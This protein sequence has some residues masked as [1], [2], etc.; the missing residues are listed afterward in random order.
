[1]TRRI[2]FYAVPVA[3]S[4]YLASNL[5]SSATVFDTSTGHPG[6]AIHG[7]FYAPTAN[8]SLDGPNGSGVFHNG[9]VAHDVHLK[10]S[11]SVNAGPSL[12]GQ[13]P[14]TF[15]RFVQIVATS[16]DAGRRPS[17]R[18]PSSRSTTTLTRRR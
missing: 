18:A 3:T 9:T 12:C 10:I 7:L 11:A 6:V 8:L 2:S 1:M 14:R 15:K 5:P 16:A 13:Q 17:S 4:G